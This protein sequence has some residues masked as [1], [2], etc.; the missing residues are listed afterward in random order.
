MAKVAYLI[1]IL[2]FLMNYLEHLTCFSSALSSFASRVE[3]LQNLG[4]SFWDRILVYRGGG[5][6]AEEVDYA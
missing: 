2:A 5:M 4:A 3:L 1:V 6:G